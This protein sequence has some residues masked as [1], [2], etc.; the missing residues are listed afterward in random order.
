MARLTEDRFA[1]LDQRLAAA[2]AVLA[3]T[4]PHTGYLR[5]PVHTAYVPADRFHPDV[6]VEW[7][8]QAVELMAAHAPF[9]GAL[10]HATGVDDRHAIEVYTRV[11]AKLDREPVEDL[12]IDFEDGYGSRPDAI[13]DAAACGGARGLAALVL[14][15]GCP[16]Y[17][18]L[19]IKSLEPATR[20]RGLRTLDM[21]LDS[22]LGAVAL[23]TGFVFTLPKVSQ[24]DQVTAMVE[25][26]EWLESVYDLPA[27]R[28]RFELQ[29]E[30]PAAIVG[31]AGI[32][33]VAPMIHA[34][35]G[36]CAGLHF[37]TYDYTAACGIAAAY[38]GLD[39]P[40][41]DHAKAV[42]QVAAAG[43]GVP[44]VDGSSNVL[45][46]G[47]TGAVHAAWRLHAG[48]VTRSLGRGYYQGWD[49]HGG[50]LVSRY[51][52]TY[53][54]YRDGLPAASGRL[55]GYVG[56]ESGAV[57]D[58]PATARALA[59]FL[60]RGLDCGALDDTEV[61]EQAGLDRASLTKLA[62]GGTGG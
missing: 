44:V 26:C 49:L 58:E 3:A 47:G 13:E 45:P 41:A 36:R 52:A 11:R 23:P 9:A 48:L 56:R 17:V 33:A 21:F 55:A 38:Q 7:G 40:A 30:L 39:H 8:R 18:G 12:R 51:A 16:P 27:G 24:V 5:Q 54:F 2:D 59:G 46:V 20:R 60:L 34:A 35:G 37:G 62:S 31:S 1:A 19:R 4:A 61:A 22:L 53:A 25:V 50:Q 10:S 14:A 43:T 6:V 29:I 28:L 42:M 32:T 57:L 15:G